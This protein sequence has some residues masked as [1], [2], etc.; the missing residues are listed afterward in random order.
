MTFGRW[1][2]YIH[3]SP[4]GSS[5]S[6]YDTFKQVEK[7]TGKPSKDLLS[8]PVLSIEHDNALAAYNALGVHTWQELDAYM[9]L[10]GNLLAGWEIEAVMKLSKFKEESPTWPP[11]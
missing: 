11:K 8:A 4:Q 2:F 6:R 3:A 9:R 7:S 5:V 1:C 10:S